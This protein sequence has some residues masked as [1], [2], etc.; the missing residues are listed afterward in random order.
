MDDSLERLSAALAGRYTIESRAGQ[1]GM[2]TVYR[3]MDQK[4]HRLVAIKVLRPELSAT[5]GSERFLREIDMSARLQH[6][7]IVPVY[8]SGDA[9]G[10]LY[11]VMPSSKENRC[12]TGSP[13]KGSCRSKKRSAS[14]EK[15]PARSPTPTLTA[16]STATS[17]R[18]T[19]CCRAGTPW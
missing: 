7:H 8:D 3:A 1:G 15:S 12:A 19:S 11:Y 2:A 9:N 14:T 6:P 16:S 4:H 17:S 18:R 13:G 5:V 10:I